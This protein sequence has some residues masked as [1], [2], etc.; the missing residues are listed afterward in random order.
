MQYFSNLSFSAESLFIDSNVDEKSFRKVGEKSPVCASSA[1]DKS[2]ALEKVCAGGV[3][4]EYDKLIDRQLER[5]TVTAIT[6]F[7]K[8]FPDACKIMQIGE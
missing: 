5:A 8:I 6:G 7:S 1:L 4:T 3:A 2:A